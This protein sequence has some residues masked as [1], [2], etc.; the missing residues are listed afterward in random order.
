MVLLRAHWPS[1]T[2]KARG[3]LVSAPTRVGPAW[4]AREGR[5]RRTRISDSR[6]FF[7]LLSAL[8]CKGE[9]AP[10]PRHLKHPSSKFLEWRA[11]V[12]EGRTDSL[13]TF[14]GNGFWISRGEKRHPRVVK[15]EA[16]GG[17]NEPYSLLSLF[18]PSF[19]ACRTPPPPNLAGRSEGGKRT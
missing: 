10:W 5:T 12:G 7:S 15:K 16:G 4:A 13:T 19:S 6:V 11:G 2:P 18:S 8:G 9:N 14:F 17:D 3:G 1:S